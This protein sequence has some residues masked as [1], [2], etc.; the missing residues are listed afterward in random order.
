MCPED[1][2]TNKD[3]ILR[4]ETKMNTIR[5]LKLVVDGRRIE[6]QFERYRVKTN[7]FHINLPENNILMLEQG[8]K[9]IVSDGYWILTQKVNAPIRLETFGTCSAGL[10]RI[11][12][13]YDIT[14]YN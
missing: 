2:K 11:G 5:E 6:A 4:A 14:L 8:V 13:N 3:L 10:T 1:G 12:V 7:L 9:K